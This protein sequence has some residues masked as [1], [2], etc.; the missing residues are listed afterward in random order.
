MAS[1]YFKGR[2]DFETLSMS[3]ISAI[4]AAVATLETMAKKHG[5]EFVSGPSRKGSPRPDMAGPRSTTR[6]KAQRRLLLALVSRDHPMTVREIAETTGL[7]EG[8]INP[9][10]SALYSTGIIHRIRQRNPDAPAGLG[11]KSTTT[12]SLTEDGITVAEEIRKSG[13]TLID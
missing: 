5:F 11:R 9:H 4:T 3:E 7:K 1:I 12:Y 8:T 2:V 6:P 10:L 13:E